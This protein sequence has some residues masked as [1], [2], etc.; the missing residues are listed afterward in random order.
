MR[1]IKFRG[2]RVSNDEW[3]YGSLD[4]APDKVFIIE[5]DEQDPLYTEF[6]EVLPTTVSESTGM[7]DAEGKEIYEGDIIEYKE[8]YRRV[9]SF[10]YYSLGAFMLRPLDECN[11]VHID[12]ISA[13]IDKRVIGN[14]YD[15]SY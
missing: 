9:K 11:C 6:I 2:Q 13:L 1:K 10:V 8:G 12:T 3:V 15:G 4:I 14:V 5:H 7:H